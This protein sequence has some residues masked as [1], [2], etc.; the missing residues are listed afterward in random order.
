MG[1]ELFKSS[2]GLCAVTATIALAVQHLGEEKVR[3]TSA[4]DSDSTEYMVFYKSRLA[5]LRNSALVRET[6]AKYKA[7]CSAIVPAIAIVPINVS[8]AGVRY[9]TAVRRIRF[10][11]CVPNTT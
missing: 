5:I 3:S 11:Q 4:R 6:P 7:S 10:A 2:I 1:S 9:K 8:R